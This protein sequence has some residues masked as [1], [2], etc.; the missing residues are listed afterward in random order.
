MYGFNLG[1]I[2]GLDSSVKTVTLTMANATESN[3][4]TLPYSNTL[5]GWADS[6]SPETATVVLASSYPNVDGYVLVMFT[7]DGSNVGQTYNIQINT[8]TVEASFKSAV[9]QV[10]QSEVKIKKLYISY[11]SVDT[12]PFGQNT[13][14]PLY[15]DQNLT[16]RA[17]SYEVDGY[18]VYIIHTVDSGGYITGTYN[19]YY[20]FQNG[21]YFIAKWTAENPPKPKLI[22]G[23]II[24]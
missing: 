16:E 20:T 8:E 18:D 2:E 3:T 10:V 21:S 4:Y 24:S 9:G 23:E 19:P 1:Q 15:L 7:F 12:A 5:R 14:L 22:T 17:H 11:E 13:I 6:P